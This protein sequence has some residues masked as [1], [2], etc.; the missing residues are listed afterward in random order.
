MYKVL[1]FLACWLLF[2][3]SGG[4]RAG[5]VEIPNR[6]GQAKVGEWVSYSLSNDM[7]R[8]FTVL[9]FE[10]KAGGRHVTIRS[11]TLM[12][13]VV[14]KESE[15]SH[16]VSNANIML[17]KYADANL[18]Q[19]NDTIEVKGEPLD[20]II[21]SG[22]KDGLPFTIYTSGKIPVFGLVRMDLM[23]EE[24]FSVHEFGYG[25]GVVN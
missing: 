10:E 19:R 9:G 20:V 8:K 25:D 22:V 3:F 17:R 24:F 12:N 7:Q 23:G 6:I 11:E 21:V 13:K 4:L 15:T 5:E 2:P 18:T 1:L 16:P 14:I